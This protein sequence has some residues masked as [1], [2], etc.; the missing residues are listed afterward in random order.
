[1]TEQQQSRSTALDSL[2]ASYL[3]CD[4]GCEEALEELVLAA[5]PVIEGVVRRRLV[6]SSSSTEAQDREDV[7]SEVVVELLGRLRVLKEED[8][9]IESFAGYIA[10]A[11]HHACDE[12]LRRKYPQRRRL[13]TKLRYL[14]DTEP[15]FAVWES[16]LEGTQK[17]QW[18]CGFKNWQSEV[19]N[20]VNPVEGWRDASSSIAPD[21]SRQ[22]VVATL[23][24]IFDAARAPVLLDELVSVLATLWGVVDRIAPIDAEQLHGSGFGDPES[25][26]IRRRGLESL[27]GEIGNL[28]VPQRVALLLNLRSGEGDS[29][30]VHLPIMGIATIRQIAGVLGIAAEEFAELWAQL[31]LDDQLIA[32]RLGVTRQQVINLRKSARERLRRKIAAR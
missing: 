3:R 32:V 19:K 18:L 31:P 16:A 8:A 4:D 26:A 22:G 27:W 30:I 13:K 10:A 20:E 28:P 25:Q 15:R 17:N 23:A 24:A 12:Y 9:A 6:F 1:V 5:R 11:T 7:C 21:R 14:L 29:P 2:L